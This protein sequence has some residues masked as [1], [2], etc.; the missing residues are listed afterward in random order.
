MNIYL[1]NSATTKPFDAVVDEMMKYYKEMYGNPSSMHK[2]G[3][4]ADALLKEARRMLEKSLH[5]EQ[6]TVIFTSG[7]TEAN[8][9][10]IRGLVYGK[11]RR[12]NKIIT[13][14]IEHP[15]VLNTFQSLEEEGFQVKYL[16]VDGEG[17]IN[18]EELK[19][20]LDEDTIFVS[21]MHVNNEVGT[22]A[23]LRDI[24]AIIRSKNSEICF[25][26]DGVQ[27]YMKT[28]LDL[29][30]WGIDAY[31]MSGHKIGGPKGIG[32]LYIKK[33]SN[34]KPTVFGGNQEMGLRSG[35]ENVPGIAGFYK[36]VEIY[37]KNKENFTLHMAEI[38]RYMMAQV[39][40]EIKD[41]KINGPETEDGAPHI[42]N[43]SFLGV[44]GEVLLHALEEDGIYVSTGSACSSRKSTGSHVLKAMG[45]Q[46]EEIEGAIRFSFS[47][48]NTTEEIDDTVASLKKQTEILRKFKRR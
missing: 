15:S 33:G 23:P 25:H 42:L 19:D 14:R 48:F 28:E 7:G 5:A 24:D 3:A 36:A 9:I 40:E 34:I 1:D 47:P 4:K 21:I 8:N 30:K 45:C 35:T 29:K 39:K 16:S 27:A 41:I 26:S 20:A 46:K 17:K 32:A 6:N 31:S 2:I 37:E 12:G 10:A 22:I 18:L 44:R 43:I 13:S 38:K 11:M